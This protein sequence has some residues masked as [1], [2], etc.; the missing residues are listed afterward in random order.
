MNRKIRDF[1]FYIKIYF[2]KG[3]YNMAKSKIT[4]KHNLAIE[5]VVN[6]TGDKIVIEVEDL[7]SRNLATMMKSFDGE[8]V[9]IAIAKTTG[10]LAEDALEVEE[11]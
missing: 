11:K 9:K 3:S 2:R 6:I 7:G 8:L 10:I 4:E 5:G 1:L